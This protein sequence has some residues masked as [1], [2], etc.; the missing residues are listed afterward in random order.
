MITLYS[1]NKV[2]SVVALI[3]V[4]AVVQGCPPV[5]V[6]VV[7]A[8]EGT[9]PGGTGGEGLCYKH[10]MGTWPNDAQNFPNCDNWTSSKPSYVCNNLN[11]NCSDA[12]TANGTCKLN[13]SSGICNC[14]CM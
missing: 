13:P 4:A 2:L 12:S 7:D 1:L 11:G 6:V 8:C 3:F 10:K 9:G 5:K 14:K